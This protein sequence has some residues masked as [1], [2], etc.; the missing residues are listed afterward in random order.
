MIKIGRV[1][2][3]GGNI[4]VHAIAPS[5]YVFAGPKGVSDTSVLAPVYR[6][7]LSSGST[8]IRFVVGETAYRDTLNAAVTI[9]QLMDGGAVIRY[10]VCTLDCQHW[11]Q[12]TKCEHIFSFC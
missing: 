1:L 5:G 7:V 6:Q 10:S 4:C 9:R 2:L 12:L 11:Y 8:D 3:R